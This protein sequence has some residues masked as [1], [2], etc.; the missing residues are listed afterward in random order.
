MTSEGTFLLLP[1]ETPAGE[2]AKSCPSLMLQVGGEGVQICR[3]HQSPVAPSST[4]PRMSFL[5]PCW[6]HAP[7]SGSGKFN[8]VVDWQN[9]I[10][11]NYFTGLFHRTSEEKRLGWGSDLHKNAGLLRRGAGLEFRLLVQAFK[12]QINKDSP[13]NYIH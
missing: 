11:A 1:R 10:Q 12:T 3:N 4:G 5:K 13:Q 9:I 6:P 7:C 2:S 8:T